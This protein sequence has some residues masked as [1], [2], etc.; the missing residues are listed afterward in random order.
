MIAKHKKLPKTILSTPVL[1]YVL[2]FSFLS[3]SILPFIIDIPSNAMPILL[4]TAGLGFLFGVFALFTTKTIMTD[5]EKLIVK[6]PLTKKEYP[7]KKAALTFT[8]TYTVNS[9]KTSL[10][11]AVPGKDPVHVITIGMG[12]SLS[13]DIEKG[14]MI[15]QTLGIEYEVPANV[16]KLAATQAKSFGGMKILVVVL[17]ITVL[18]SLGLGIYISLTR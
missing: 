15:A 14:R 9:T 12:M 6:T 8:Y 1:F 17:V 2:A 10:Y 11:L 7:T 3:P 18:A 16:E 4:S 13:N 5:N